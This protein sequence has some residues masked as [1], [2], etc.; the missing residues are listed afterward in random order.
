MPQ[1]VSD[2]AAS[3]DELVYERSVWA[4]ER[5]SLQMALDSAEHEIDR[6]KK[7]LRSFRGRFNSEGFMVEADRDKVPRE[8]RCELLCA[9]LAHCYWA[10]KSVKP[11]FKGVSCAVL[12]LSKIW[13][14]LIPA[15]VWNTWLNW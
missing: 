2:G 8:C 4:N 10:V 3:D 15:K 5:L 1:Y 14:L 11:D 12:L 13:N 6:L 9:C 7:E